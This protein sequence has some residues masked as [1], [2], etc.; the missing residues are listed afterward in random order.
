MALAENRKGRGV[1][2]LA[3][4]HDA[5][6]YSLMRRPPVYRVIGL[7]VIATVI[8]AAISLSVGK[9]HAYSALLGGLICVL[10]NLYFVRKTFAYSGARAARQIV[11]AFYKG[12]AI[13]LVLTAV[14]FA[15][16]Y[17]YVKPL[18]P[19]AMLI[20]F[21]LVQTTNWFVPWILG[22]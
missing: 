16:V 4:H 9:V 15:L 19:A 17:V 8:V 12:E 2:N 14:L 21:I 10:P 6:D 5:R 7:Q 1:S 13:K 3:G 20:A 22:R 11:N 18:E